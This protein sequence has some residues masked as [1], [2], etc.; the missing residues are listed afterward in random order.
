MRYK[1]I[2]SYAEIIKRE[3]IMLQRGMNF[4]IKPS[5]SIILVSVR[6]GAPYKD[7]WHEDTGLLE[8]EGHDEPKRSGIDPKK[9]DQPLRTTS[10]T[11]T[12]N[13]KFFD[14]ALS[15]KE[16]KRKPETVQ[17]YEKISEGVWCDRGRYELIDVTIMS[18]GVR[19]VCRFFLRPAK[20][21][22]A[23]EP[24]LKQTRV[25][26][27]A[28]KVEVWKRDQGH[29]VICG[30]NDNLHFDHDVPYSKGGSSIT[31]KNVRLL[32]ARHNLSKSDKIMTFAPWLTTIAS[33]LISRAG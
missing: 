7:R 17:V 14:A 4:R 27:T 18:D 2:I 1:S 6:E 3:D 29:C 10:G 11:L 20:T 12:E 8:Y 19:K 30:R 28:I 25:I 33:A 15:F 5:Y 24:L 23:N 21:P 9:L 31:A 22:R 26:P 13:G 16:K 32:C